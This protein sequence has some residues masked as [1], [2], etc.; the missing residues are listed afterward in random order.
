MG[1]EMKKM[2][3]MTREELQNLISVLAN[4]I[5]QVTVASEEVGRMYMLHT[6]SDIINK[7]VGDPYEVY[8]S[9]ISLLEKFK[10]WLE[11]QK[12]D[13]STISS[14]EN[15]IRY[16]KNEEEKIGITT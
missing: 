11:S 14:I 13:R 2:S 16:M 4:F 9:F 12:A 6:I 10:K 7:S 3:N 5:S 15:F 8:P 1:E